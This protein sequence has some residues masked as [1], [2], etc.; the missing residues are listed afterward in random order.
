[1]DQIIEL[2]NKYWPIIVAAGVFMDT[3]SGYLPD[4][5]LG[6]IGITRRV[7]TALKGGKAK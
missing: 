5:W 2:L 7:V 6:Y 3:I 1:M 4:K